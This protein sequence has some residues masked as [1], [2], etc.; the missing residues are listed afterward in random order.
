MPRTALLQ[1]VK[2]SLT[3]LLAAV[4]Q[5]GCGQALLDAQQSRDGTAGDVG[6]TP[7]IVPGASLVVQGTRI[8]LGT[9]AADIE[10][11]YGVPGREDSHSLLFRYAGGLTT[12]F[13]DRDGNRLLDDNDIAI[14]LRVSGAY[15]GNTAEGLG[16]GNSLAEIIAAFGQPILRGPP[17]EAHVLSDRP[18]ALYPAA[19]IAF[20]LDDALSDTVAAVTVAL[21]ARLVPSGSVDVTGPAVQLGDVR[22]M[23]GDSGSPREAL[24]S[25]LGMADESYSYGCGQT[26][27]RCFRD[28]FL[29]L[30]V[31]CIGPAGS[32]VERVRTI[33]LRWPLAAASSA[34]LGPGSRRL[35]VEAAWGS[36]I[37][38]VDADPLLRGAAVVTYLP[39]D[40]PWP[41]GVVYDAAGLRVMAI[42]LGYVAPGG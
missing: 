6:P 4:A 10:R 42:A 31:E 33:V 22:L 21:P 12:L 37:G 9:P 26:G 13:A 25:G 1:F 14:G 30:G 2:S 34:E 32:F 39:P 18:L 8:D 19:G 5:I 40:A 17:G 38:Q 41:V 23:A 11:L 16:V 20:S 36:P 29:L 3:L 24:A 28:F 27:E 15:P 35:A 7:D